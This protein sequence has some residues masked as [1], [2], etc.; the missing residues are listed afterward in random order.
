V[1]AH[2]AEEGEVVAGTYDGSYA[3]KSQPWWIT[4]AV[5]RRFAESAA[6]CA[7]LMPATGTSGYRSSTQTSSTV[8]ALW[9]VWTTGTAARAQNGIV[10]VPR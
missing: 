6:S 5:R 8:S 2:A 9:S 3:A 1:R 4:R 7:A 10:A